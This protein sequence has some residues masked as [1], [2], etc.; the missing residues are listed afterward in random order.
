MH[1]W[2]EYGGYGGGIG[3]FLVTLLILLA[4][5]LVCREIVCWY[6]KINKA[7]ELLERQNVL[8]ERIEARL[9]AP[10]APAAAPPLVMPPAR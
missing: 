1:G 3:A 10:A 8:L 4:L 2:Y 6:W 7:V 5:F 9:S